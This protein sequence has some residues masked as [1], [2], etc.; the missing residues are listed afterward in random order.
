MNKPTD[1]N[2]TIDT[3]NLET[4]KQNMTPKIENKT[5][6]GEV[7][8]PFSLIQDMLNLFPNHIFENPNL[9]WL[10]PACGCG[11]FMIVLFK[12]LMIS[13]EKCFPD[14]KKRRD[15]ILKNML[16]MVEINPEHVK[17]LNAL[18]N[19]CNK[20][21]IYCGNFLLMNK[22]DLGLKKNECFDI[23]I[24]N[25]PYN[26][27]GLK[28]VPTNQKINKKQDGITI[29]SAFIKHSITLLKKQ[30]FLSMIV[31]SIWMKPDKIKM[32]NYMLSYK[33]H[34]IRCFSNTETKLLFKGQAQTPTCYFLLEK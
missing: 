32:Y 13:L 16:Y 24:G 6:Y 29:W 20:K 18:F 2:N 30:G 34:Y 11:Y 3:I 23:I 19:N 26:S 21:N 31:P 25:P 1:I 17:T 15:H 12:K 5:L 7:N 9:K 4:F 14:P 22:T 33:I 8:T 10:D 27:N 28:K